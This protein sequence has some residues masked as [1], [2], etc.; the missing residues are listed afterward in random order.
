MEGWITSGR[1]ELHSGLNGLR[2]AGGNIIWF[3]G[4]INDYR[5]LAG[6]MDWVGDGQFFGDGAGGLSVL[7]GGI[8]STEHSEVAAVVCT[9]MLQVGGILDLTG[10]Q[11]FFANPLISLGGQVLGQ[12]AS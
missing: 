10:T 2:N 11:V 6:R 12:P 5:S 1:L 8:I 3:H 4:N 9:R 7:Y